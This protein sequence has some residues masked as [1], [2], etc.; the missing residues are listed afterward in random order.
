MD[1]KEPRRED[2]SLVPEDS[3]VGTG[4]ETI[5]AG[6]SLKRRK[7]HDSIDD[8]IKRA[9]QKVYAYVETSS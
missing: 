7:P 5:L 8:D 2:I 3:S 9:R 1:E 6:G 4:A